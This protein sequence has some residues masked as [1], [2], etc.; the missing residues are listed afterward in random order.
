METFN[1]SRART[2]LAR[3]WR[4]KKRRDEMELER[5][6]EECWTV[7]ASVHNWTPGTSKRRKKGG[8][9]QRR[10][11][12]EGRERKRMMGMCRVPRCDSACVVVLSC[13]TRSNNSRALASVVFPVFRP[14]LA[15]CFFL[16][17]INSYSRPYIVRR[18]SYTVN[19]AISALK[20]DEFDRKGVEDLMKRRFIIAP[21]FE[22]YGATAGMHIFKM[23]TLSFCWW[24][25][26]QVC[27]TM[28]QLVVLSR[29]TLLLCGDNTLFSMRTC[30]RL[31]ALHSLLSL[32]WSNYISFDT[33]HHNNFFV[34]IIYE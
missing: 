26:M 28:V 11:C 12:C 7:S 18:M 23:N 34:F 14:S 31:I 3:E 27:M 19:Q 15:P 17:V 13:P 4:R 32:F 25:N 29:P 21:S 8:T 5:E 30:W 2:S 22:I 33:R 6:K 1:I 16:P 20:K 10:G 24:R 9:K